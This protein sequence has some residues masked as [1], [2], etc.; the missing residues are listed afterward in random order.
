M[1][2][3]KSFYIGFTL[4]VYSLQAQ[5]IRIAASDLLSEFIKAPLKAY[6]EEYDLNLVIESIGSLPALD[7]LRSNEI[8]LA[9]LA[10]PEENPLPRAEFKIFPFAYAASV[11]VVNQANP[12]QDISI[13]QLGGIFGSREELRVNTWGDL[14]FSGLSGRNINPLVISSEYS[15]SQE[16]FKNKVLEGSFLNPSVVACS[17]SEIDYLISLNVASIAVTSRIS[18]SMSL[19]TLMLSKDSDSPAFGPTPNN[20]HYGDYSLRLP[21]YITFN[22]R[23]ETKLKSLI[24]ELFGDELA[25]CL[26]DNGLFSLPENIRR[27]LI[28]DLDLD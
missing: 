9:I 25:S 20:I 18:N 2:Y 11:I 5:E 8:D 23:D 19:K 24:R 28:M 3:I 12:T 16:L 4:F 6:A 10:V 21:F 27:R 17:E 13:D 22:Q 1:N 26:T 14:G 7:K 15:I